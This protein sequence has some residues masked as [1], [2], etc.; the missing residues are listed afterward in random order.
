MGGQKR[1]VQVTVAAV[2]YGIASVVLLAPVLNYC[3]EYVRDDPAALVTISGIRALMPL[4]LTALPLLIA[5]G[6]IHGL[7]RLRPWA[8]CATL[9]TCYTC[10][11]GLPILGCWL[12]A[13]HWLA[14]II[15]TLHEAV[16]YAIYLLAACYLSYAMTRP[17]IRDAFRRAEL[18]HPAADVPTPPLG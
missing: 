12:F 4:T 18:P 3:L 15:F 16:P 11:L 1:P 10:V 13:T 9:G 8:R 2:V 7:I 6:V 17:H 5:V 14:G